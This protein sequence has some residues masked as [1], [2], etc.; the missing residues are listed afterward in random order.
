MNDTIDL[1]S[2]VR[3]QLK[4]PR[5][6]PTR[7]DLP[8]NSEDSRP[9]EVYGAVL[10][11]E[12]FQ[13]ELLLSPLFT[14]DQNDRA[15]CEAALPVAGLIA[16]ELAGL[17]AHLAK[18]TLSCPVSAGERSGFCPIPEVV[19][20]RYVRLLGLDQPVPAEAATWIQSQLT[21]AELWMGM[22]LARRPVWRSA[23]GRDLL[24]LVLP[25]MAKGSALSLDKLT[26][27][28]E[29]VRTYRCRTQV[30]LLH[31][32]KSLIEAYRIDSEHPLFENPALED[33]QGESIRSHQCDEAVRLH[34][35]AMAREIL[36][37]FERVSQSV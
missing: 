29:F 2:I 32:L 30:D 17:M 9:G 4:R 27:L 10:K 19:L 33:K 5:T 7:I 31:G 8:L 14:P 22:S 37:D 3:D 24:L 11:M 18:E 15:A 21:G 26:F 25:V 23:T 35:V 36:G 34:R 28:T 16:D 20:V 12:E 13:Q 6:L 1:L